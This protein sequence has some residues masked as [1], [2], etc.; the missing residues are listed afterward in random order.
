MICGSRRPTGSWILRAPIKG[1]WRHLHVGSFPW[2]LLWSKW[3]PPKLH[4][5]IWITRE[6]TA[7]W[8]GLCFDIDVPFIILYISIIITKTRTVINMN[9][10]SDWRSLDSSF[11]LSFFLIPLP[12]NEFYKRNTELDWQGIN[13]RRETRWTGITLRWRQMIFGK[14]PPS[15]SLFS[16]FFSIH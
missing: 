12:M 11:L 9:S 1:F 3:F 10:A 2:F 5:N 6:I 14:L 4:Y 13:K 8:S 16:Y 15:Y 7:D